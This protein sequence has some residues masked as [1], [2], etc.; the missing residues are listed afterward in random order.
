LREVEILPKAKLCTFSP[1]PRWT[2][3]SQSARFA[4]E[5]FQEPF[6]EWVKQVTDKPVVGVGRYTSPDRMAGLVRKGVLDFIGAARPSIADPFLPKKIDEGR[7]EDIRECIGCN[8]CVTGDLLHVPIRCTQNPTMGEE[9]RR[10]WHP[11]RCETKGSDD[12]VLIVGGGPAGLEAARLLGSRGY[13]VT[14]AEASE[15]FGG[16]VEEVTR[17]PGLASWRRVVDYRLQ[18]LR[19]LGNVEMYRESE[20]DA[21]QV[22]ELGLEHV[23]LATGSRWRRDGRGRRHPRGVSMSA[24]ARS[25]APDEVLGGT[26]LEGPVVV[27]D[28]DHYYMA[29]VIAEKLSAQGLEVVYATPAPEAA[30]WTRNTLEQAR[31][32]AR[33]IELGVRLELSSVIREVREG[34]IELSCVYSGRSRSLRAATLVPVT[35]RDPVDALYHELSRDP[36]GLDGAGIK[37][38]TRIGDCLAPGLLAAAVYS[39]HRYARELDTPS[40]SPDEAP[41]KREL[42]RPDVG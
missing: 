22:V 21:A 13:H 4:E 2:F 12:R 29:S 39:G 16:H 17:L 24:R 34:E 40:S 8:I 27:Y 33:L 3:D 19:T 30:T 5:G 15:A 6:I 7:A 37:T 25:V 31:V 26:A 18:Q 32:Q 11:E 20:L 9:W 14:L 23:A 41:F 35:M 28:D 38:V 36:A 42:V 1:W 10:G